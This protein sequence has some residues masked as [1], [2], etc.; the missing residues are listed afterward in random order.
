MG[1]DVW[2]CRSEI[3]KASKKG[4]KGNTEFFT[5]HEIFE[6]FQETLLLPDFP[7]CNFDLRLVV[8]HFLE[9]SLHRLLLP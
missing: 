1:R 8:H 7:L 6:E 3:P 5:S 9:E 2:P 4:N